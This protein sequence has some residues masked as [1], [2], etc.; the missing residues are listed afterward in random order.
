MSDGQGRAVSKPV[1][2]GIVCFLCAAAYVFFMFYVG[3]HKEQT[4]TSKSAATAAYIRIGTF[5]TA[6]DY[7]PLLIA[8][9]KGWIQAELGVP[10]DQIEFTTFQTLPSINEAFAAG[11]LDVVATSEVA[12]L[13]GRAAGIDVRIT[14]LDATLTEG[15]LVR[16]ASAIHELKDLKGRR[17]AV[18]SG[19]AMHFGLVKLLTA[20]GINTRQVQL[21]NMVPADAAAAF[22]TGQIEAWSVWPPWPEQQVV[23]KTGRFLPDAEAKIQSV[24]VMRQGFIDQGNAAAAIMRAIGRG[25]VWIEQ[26][27]SESI[28]LIARQLQLPEAVV[29]LAWPKHDWHAQLSPG[30]THDVQEKAEF[31]LSEKMIQ[32]PVSAVDMMEPL[33]Q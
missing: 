16:S 33:S 23:Q 4:S 7:A 2:I 10:N 15:I 21:I 11:K 28:A 26:N 27:P 20:A 6:I 31:L 30:I 3:R 19:S 24:V 8:Q 12:A 13:I 32:H 5:S 22:A 18:L 14:G 9:S 29:R 17:V 1:A 25:K